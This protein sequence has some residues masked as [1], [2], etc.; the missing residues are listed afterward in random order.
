M[1]RVQ[2]Y[3]EQR[4]PLGSAEAD[5]LWL[6]D[7]NLRCD[8][9]F[10]GVRGKLASADERFRT[11]ATPALACA[12]ATERS[13]RRTELDAPTGDRFRLRAAAPGGGALSL[14]RV[15]GPGKRAE[16]LTARPAIPMTCDALD[17]RQPG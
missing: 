14:V 13:P 15:P 8:A 6:G 4:A 3:H 17:D 5:P 11:P 10:P 7:K 2:V 12:L 16:M 9:A 1:R